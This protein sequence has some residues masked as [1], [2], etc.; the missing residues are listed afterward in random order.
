MKQEYRVIRPF[1]AAEPISGNEKKFAPGDIVICDA[2]ETGPTLTLETFEG[3]TAYFLVERSIFEMCCKW[4]SRTA[5][6]I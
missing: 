3:F 5:G 1:T 2:A 6:S 4:I